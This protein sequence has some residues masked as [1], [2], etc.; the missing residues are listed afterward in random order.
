[1]HYRNFLRFALSLLA[2]S[3]Y[4][5]AEESASC[6][7]QGPRIKQILPS[8]YTDSK[9]EPSTTISEDQIFVLIPS[10][11]LEQP[12][13]TK[14]FYL[15]VEGMSAPIPLQLSSEK[16]RLKT[17]IEHKIAK[18]EAITLRSSTSLPAKKK[19]TLHVAAGLKALKYGTKTEQIQ[20][21]VFKVR[22]HFT[23]TTRCAMGY[24]DGTCNPLTHA[25]LLFTSPLPQNFQ[26]SVFLRSPSGRRI[27]G[28]YSRLWFDYTESNWGFSFPAPF[29]PKEEWSLELPGDIKD[30]SGRSLEN[31]VSLPR[32]IKFGDLSPL[33]KFDSQFLVLE[34]LSNPTVPLNLRNV[35]EAAGTPP[36]VRAAKISEPYEM[37]KML[38]A[39]DQHSQT[40]QKEITPLLGKDLSHPITYAKSDSGKAFEKVG[41]PLRGPG[42]Y[43]LEAESEVH[44]QVLQQGKTFYSSTAAL[45]T[46]L[47]LHFKWGSETS[48]IWVTNL[49]TGKPIEAAEV[50]VWDCNGNKIWEGKSDSS[51]LAFPANLQSSNANYTCEWPT[52]LQNYSQYKSRYLVVAKLKDDI[53]FVIGSMDRGIEQWRFNLPYSQIWAPQILHTFFSQP[54][55]KRG[56]T[57]RMKHFFRSRTSQGFAQPKTSKQPDKI[58]LT[59]SGSGQKFILPLKWTKAGEAHSEWPVPAN[60]RLGTYYLESPNGEQQLSNRFEVL[61]FKPPLTSAQLRIGTPAS[62]GSSLTVPVDFQLTY[63]AGGG[64]SNLP[65]RLTV[66]STPAPFHPAHFKDYIFSGESAALN[67]PSQYWEQ[68]V[69]TS[70]YTPVRNNTSLVPRSRT[71]ALDAQG[72]LSTSFSDL[73]LPKVPTR[74]RIQAEYKDPNGEIRTSSSSRHYLP[75]GKTIGIKANNLLNTRRSFAFEVVVVDSQGQPLQNEPISVHLFER[76]AFTHRKKLFGKFYGYE[77]QTIVKPR[78]RVCAGTTSKRGTV[79]C[80]SELPIAGNLILEASSDSSPEVAVNVSLWVAEG[81]EWWFAPQDHDR[82]DIVSEK[83]EYQPGDQALFQVRMPYQSATALVTVER[84]G[85][86]D[87]FVQDITSKD[88]TVRIPIKKNYAPNAYVSVAAV[89]GRLNPAKHNFNVDFSKPA[90]KYGLTHIKVGLA[91]HRID[92][93]VTP[94]KHSYQVGESVTLDFSTQHKSN[95]LPDAEIAVAVVDEGILDL[96][97]NESVQLLA[98]LLGTRPLDVRYFNNL[99]Q[100]FGNRHFGLKANPFGGGGGQSRPREIF[101]GLLYWNSELGTDNQGK[102]QVSFPTNDSVT[103]FKVLAVATRGSNLFGQAEARFAV[104]KDFA[105]FSGAPAVLRSEDTF[106]LVYTLR[107]STEHAALLETRAT[108]QRPNGSTFTLPSQKHK[109]NA[110]ES[111][112]ITW[113]NTRLPDEG[114][115]FIRVTTLHQGKVVDEMRSP[116][117][118]QSL[119]PQRITEGSFFQLKSSLDKEIK[120]SPQAVSGKGEVDLLFSEGFDGILQSVRQHMKKYP[121]SCLEQKISKAIVTDDD[122]LWTDIT[123]NFAGYVSSTG[124]LKYFPSQ[125]EGSLMLSSYVLSAAHAAQKQLPSPQTDKVIHSLER[126]LEGKSH[127]QSTAFFHPKETEVIK[128]DTLETL[129]RYGKTYFHILA[130]TLDELKSL[131]SY[132]IIQL[133]STLERYPNTKEVQ[134]A[135]ALVE[136]ELLRRIKEFDTVLSLSEDNSNNMWWAMVSRDVAM[137][138]LLNL[139]S[140]IPK[141]EYLLGKTLR[142]AT[143]MQANGHWDLTTANVWGALTLREYLSGNPGKVQGTVDIGSNKISKQLIQGEKAT[144]P[145]ENSALLLNLTNTSSGEPWLLLQKREAILRKNEF[146]KGYRVQRSIRVLQ[147][148][149]PQS[150]SVGD[151]L[152]I[153]LKIQAEGTR[154]WVVLSD[155]LPP[156]A[157]I[158]GSGLRGQNSLKS[159]E[160]NTAS[161][162]FIERGYD[163]YRAYFELLPEGTHT[164]SYQIRLNTSGSFR[165]PSTHIEAM[166]S[167][168]M[169]GESPTS[170][171]QIEP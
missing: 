142:A 90:L 89:R 136:K 27:Q 100:V 30:Q 116:I 72:G 58:T 43:V 108:V 16:E 117:P 119:T 33:V 124:L 162:T 56:E 134:K 145:L 78:N 6:Q 126:F 144:F 147:Q 74:Y 13:D 39:V 1:M 97:K 94:S 28:K 131:P 15:Q 149:A 41:I 87:T 83:E 156:G 2:L 91:E 19:I 29:S 26:R 164:I 166:Y 111:R 120:A 54:I 46:N 115:N 23:A 92:M 5:Q 102:A 146:S 159:D 118:I 114:D 122:E 84:E 14:L 69:Y 48:L 67:F 38:V 50:S 55:I 35:K 140:E 86:L 123:N 11:P 47:G 155:P 8:S 44:A 170:G 52:D 21:F 42:F 79:Q 98:S 153:S 157:L 53:S 96:K 45:V 62:T 18:P 113:E 129:A 107:N 12:I 105:L 135:T 161:P 65:V 139:T 17:L 25:Y 51:G 101:K 4:L 150:Y 127:T 36:V 73:P 37:W 70:H 103:S 121:Y 59:H 151:I 68:D 143:E 130:L 76:Q 75:A 82:M 168:S 165:L 77:N 80:K 88:P 167:P 61:D 10:C 112:T 141:F 163:S 60:A 138:K 110:G 93:N 171:I 32:S 106:D 3:C 64:A 132:S 71:E 7:L 49:A 24:Q 99:M 31:T 109:L 95:M 133:R 40:H 20:E 66:D 169:F 158:L 9:G 148:K 63:L 128:I 160:R 104:T 154:T 137:L 125:S 81:D 152:E 57:I 85:I 22:P 34:S